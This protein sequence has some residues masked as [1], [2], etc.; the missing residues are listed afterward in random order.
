MNIL[1]K[2]MVVV[3]LF[4]ITTKD[5]AA[6]QK[7]SLL[8]AQ[9]KS[10]VIA[11]PTNSNL[12]VGEKFH[13]FRPIN[14]KNVK[15][16]IATLLVV[17]N[18]YYGVKITDS[19]NDSVLKPGDFLVFS[20]SDNRTD[21][22]NLSDPVISRTPLKRS[23]SPGL[24]LGGKVGSLGFGGELSARIS[25]VI[26]V[27]VGLN[28]FS[29]SLSDIEPT[30]EIKYKGSLTLNS[31]SALL[32]LHPFK[33]VFRLSTGVVLNNNNAAF[34]VQSLQTYTFGST[35]FTPSETGILKGKI[36][37]DKYAPYIGIGWGSAVP[38]YKSIGFMFDIGMIYQNSPHVNFEATGLIA[39]TA[40]QDEQVEDDLKGWKAYGVVSFGLSFKIY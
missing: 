3:V 26:N 21:V 34:E 11:K 22:P 14:G 37:F 16:G 39:P 6:Q 29:Y 7:F 1:S 20:T 32:D 8:K 38:R 25:S 9:G 17:R 36:N 33:G 18:Q 27:R 28:R 31:I 5:L 12:Q 40:D 10:G 15:I 24:A 35:T 4:F 19:K 23:V 2:V 13:V 30:Q